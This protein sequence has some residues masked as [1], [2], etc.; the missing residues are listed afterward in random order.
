MRTS[1]APSW[2]GCL[3]VVNRMDV[4]S[5][6]KSHPVHIPNIAYFYPGF[7][8]ALHGPGM[9][10]FRRL[11]KAAKAYDSTSS[12]PLDKRY[13]KKPLAQAN[14]AARA[15]VVSYLTKLYD[16]VAETMPDVKDDTVDNDQADTE[17]LRRG[18]QYD[19]GEDE[20]AKELNKRVQPDLAASHSTMEAAGPASGFNKKNTKRSVDV[21]HERAGGRDV[22]WLPPGRMSQMWLQYKLQAGVQPPASFPTFWREPCSQRCNFP[23]II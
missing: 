12:P 14:T 7:S 8:E 3:Q 22:R 9:S 20:Y 18:V 13:L 21:M 17:L 10:R 23:Y 15:D 4:G 11:S 16:S 5:H 1:M 2:H 6:D 19:L